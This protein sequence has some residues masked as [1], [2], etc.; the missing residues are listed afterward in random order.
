M[1]TWKSILRKAAA[2]LGLLSLGSPALADPQALPA[3]VPTQLKPAAPVAPVPAVAARPALWAVKDAD[4]TIYLFGTIHAL[5]PGI[6]WFDGPVAKAFDGSQELVTEVADVGSL[7]AAQTLM[8]R[9]LLPEGESLRAKL[10][11]ADRAAYDAA[12]AKA[13]IPAAAIDKFKPWYAAVA[14]SS[15]PL[16]RAGYAIDQGVEIQLAAKA[17]AQQ[18]QQ[19]ALETVAYQLGLFDSLP[20]ASQLSYLRQVVANLDNV[21]TQIES[22]IGEWSKGDADKLAQEMNADTSDP[23]LVKALLTQRNHA[24]ADWIG[25]RMEQPGT[26]FLAV[27]AG[28]LAGPDSVQTALAAKG[29]AAQRLQ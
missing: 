26:V 23:V 20:E 4:T 15:L 16:M 27:G 17:K 1:R 19:G 29:I 22:L 7:D 2:T 25:K 24:W 14:L 9:A 12:L 10:S 21:T 8:S 11:D 28:H 6:A 5:K 3:A 13:S 18:K